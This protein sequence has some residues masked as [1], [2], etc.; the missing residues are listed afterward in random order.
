MKDRPFAWAGRWQCPLREQSEV[1]GSH[2]TAVELP[3]TFDVSD[4][5]NHCWLQGASILQV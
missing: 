1:A 4:G 2:P 3:G 5:F